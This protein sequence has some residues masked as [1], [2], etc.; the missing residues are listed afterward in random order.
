MATQLLSCASN[1]EDETP[2]N[3]P[4]TFE[5]KPVWFNGPER[6]HYKNRNYDIETH[7]FFDL[8]PFESNERKE[9]SY[10]LL[11]PKQSD[12]GYDIDLKSGQFFKKYQYCPQDDVWKTYQQKIEKPPYAEGFIPRLMDQFGRPMRV[13][14][15]G[16]KPYFVEE[17][18]DV[19]YSQ[20]ARIVGGVVQQY[21][22]SYPCAGREKWLSTMVMIGVVPFDPS[23]KDVASLD[24]LKK[25]VDWNEVKAFMENGYGRK[26]GPPRDEPVYRI[27]SEVN[28][29]SAWKFGFEKGHLFTMPEMNTIRSSCYKLYDSIWIGAQRARTVTEQSILKK[30]DFV[31]RAKEIEELRNEFTRMTVIQ[32]SYRSGEEEKFDLIDKVEKKEMKFGDFFKTV[33]F[34]YGSRLKTCFE[35]VRPANITI[36]PERHWFFTYLE[37]FINLD[38]LGSFYMCSRKA[39]VE[40]PIINNGKRTYNK[41]MLKNCTGSELDLSFDSSITYLTGLKRSNREHYRYIEDDIGIGGSHQKIQAWV[42]HDGKSLSCDDKFK[43]ASEPLLFPDDIRWNPFYNDELLRK[44]GYIR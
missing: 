32:D 13:Y 5:A 7:A 2:K 33:Y 44:D 25:K 21:C 40:N 4:I 38:Q 14:V 29:E 6:F 19:A 18:K 16:E 41:K 17:K 39:W 30:E 9:L 20:R 43:K 27:I 15:F 11:T 37:S 3:A 10:V 36:S 31:K 22:H 26:L 23:M 12:F 8:A 34:E 28:S 42:Y 1:S 24:D 35:Y